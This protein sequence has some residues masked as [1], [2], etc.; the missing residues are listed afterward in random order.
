MPPRGESWRYALDPQGINRLLM[1]AKGL[2][3][4]TVIKSL[5][6]AGLRADEFVH[7]NAQWLRA[8]Q[9]S[10]PPR[11]DCR[12]HKK[13]LERG[14]WRPKSKAGT[15][16]IFVVKPLQAD[17]LEYLRVRPQGFARARQQVWRITDRVAARAGMKD[18]IFPH[19]LRATCASILA[20][21]MNATQLAYVM[22]WSDLKEAQNYV[23]I[24][25]AKV[26][27]SAVMERM[28]S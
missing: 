16:D 28:Y 3:E 15:R 4:R 18:I 13:C 26:N 25:Q 6:Y 9:I 11:C 2:E 5:I 27:A 21:S 8:G 14:M 7:L 10:I 1:Q 17:L 20:K 19:A 22:G 23:D 12:N 24:S